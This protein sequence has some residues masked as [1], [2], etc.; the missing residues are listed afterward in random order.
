MMHMHS[1]NP[2]PLSNLADVLTSIGAPHDPARAVNIAEQTN[3]YST[4]V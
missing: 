2:A 3:Q 1:T 4:L